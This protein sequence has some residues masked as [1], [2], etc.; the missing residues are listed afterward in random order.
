MSYMGGQRS[1]LSRQRTGQVDHMGGRMPSWACVAPAVSGRPPSEPWF[2]TA[3]KELSRV[4]DCLARKPPPLSQLLLLLKRWL[5]TLSTPSCPPAVQTHA[6]VPSTNVPGLSLTLTRPHLVRTLPLFPS[7]SKAQRNR[8][9]GLVPPCWEG[10]K[11]NLK[12]PSL[13]CP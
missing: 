13:P 9:F 12:T 5:W 4:L 8:G 1:G 11:V 3:P 6:Q 2:P 10:R 7:L